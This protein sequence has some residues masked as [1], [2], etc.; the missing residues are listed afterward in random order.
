MELYFRDKLYITE[1]LN[2]P[3]ENVSK[4]IEN[5]SNQIDTQANN[6]H[7]INI[8]QILQNTETQDSSTEEL[9]EP[10]E[11]KQQES[12]SSEDNKEKEGNVVKK[13]AEETFK[14]LQGLTSND[15]DAINYGNEH[16]N[17]NKIYKH[18]KLI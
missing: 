7:K 18:N 2:E 11:P 9:Q 10:Q 4:F 1:E 5:H 12:E 3:E 14:L 13:Q 17:Y 15:Q 8:I 6:D 16:I